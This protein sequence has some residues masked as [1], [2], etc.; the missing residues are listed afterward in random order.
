MLLVLQDGVRDKLA[1][2]VIVQVARGDHR[3]SLV[4]VAVEKV[5]NIVVIAVAVGHIRLANLLFLVS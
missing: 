1:L 3:P 5:N 4:A 2:V